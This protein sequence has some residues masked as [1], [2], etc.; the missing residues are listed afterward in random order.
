[1]KFRLSL[2]SSAEDRRR[3]AEKLYSAIA[4]IEAGILGGLFGS[5]MACDLR[6]GDDS[7]VEKILFRATMAFLA[8][9]I[10]SLF[11]LGHLLDRVTPPSHP[12]G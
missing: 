1:M 5:A 11:A 10:V 3:K 6:Y 7:T 9:F 4:Y 8:F 2:G 12:P